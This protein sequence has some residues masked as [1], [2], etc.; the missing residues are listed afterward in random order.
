MSNKFLVRI[1]AGVSAVTGVLVLIYVFYPILSYE[2]GVSGRF[3]SYVSPVPDQRNVNTRNVGS[4][5]QVSKVSQGGVD[6]TRAS[7]WFATEAESNFELP[8]VTHY[9]I[10]IPK[11]DIENATVAIGGEDLSES[12]IQYPGTALPGKLGNSVIFGHS[13]LPQ[14]YD[15]EDYLAIFS[16]LPTL[17]IGDEIFARYD[18]VQYK[19]EVEN[20]FEVSPTDIQVLEQNS[21]DSFLTVVTCT[22]PGHPLRPKRLIVRARVVP[23]SA[24][25]GTSSFRN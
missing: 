3:G 10:T 17:E 6:Y 23:Y 8:S 12:L 16:T 4:V 11:L 25:A 14:F 19:Y 5:E 22:P 9:N 15:P 1:L 20:M 24:N 2:F 7:N 13:I 18:G 21:S